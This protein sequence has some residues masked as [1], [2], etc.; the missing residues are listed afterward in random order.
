MVH[1]IEMKAALTGGFFHA[2]HFEVRIVYSVMHSSITQ[3][4]VIT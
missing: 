3:N 4:Y 2:E 1:R